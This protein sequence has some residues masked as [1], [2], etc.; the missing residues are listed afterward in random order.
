[1]ISVLQSLN[2]AQFSNASC[3][4]AASCCFVLRGSSP[5]AVALVTAIFP[6]TKIYASQR[7]YSL[8]FV[9]NF[10]GSLCK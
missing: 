8:D 10:I 1:M 3:V 2:A 4:A 5:A 6:V 9:K 7:L